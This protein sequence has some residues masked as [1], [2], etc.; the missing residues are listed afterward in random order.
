[1]NNDNI[2]SREDI[3]VIGLKHNV[4]SIIHICDKG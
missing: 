2:K 1:M 3:F 4:L